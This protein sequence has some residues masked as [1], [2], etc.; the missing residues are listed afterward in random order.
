MASVRENIANNIRI[1]RE[2]TGLT[3]RELAKMLDVG[4]SHVSN[5]ESGL[6]SPKI[7]T[8]IEM[9]KI[10]DITLEAMYGIS[11]DMGKKAQQMAIA[12][13]NAPEDIRKIVDTAL[14]LNQP[15]S[16]SPRQRSDKGE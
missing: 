5:W 16:E 3:Q 6:N 2:A 1:N 7:E 4:Y 14:K 11:D 10:F 12:Y 8:L 9:C 15:I 13:Q